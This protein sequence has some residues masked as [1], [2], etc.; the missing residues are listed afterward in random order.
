MLR[1]QF[2]DVKATIL[3]WPQF[4]NNVAILGWM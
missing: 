4:Q 3:G 2:W 1:P